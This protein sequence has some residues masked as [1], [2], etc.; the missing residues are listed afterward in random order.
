[1][2]ST[3]LGRGVTA[4]ATAALDDAVAAAVEARVLPRAA[5]QTV[6][7][8][9]ASLSRAVASVDAA[10]AELRLERVLTCRRVTVTPS[11][12]GTAELHALLSADGAA[13]VY[14]AVDA[15]ARAADAADGRGVDQR[16][17]DALVDLVMA[18]TSG[19]PPPA[20]SALVHVTVPAAT[21]LGLGDEPGEL[22]G[23]GPVPASVARRLA[24]GGNWRR[25][26]IDP[27]TGAVRDV[28]RSA[29]TP[30]AALADLIRARDRTCR[31][32]GCRQPCARCGLDHL[33]PWPAGPTTA[34][35]LAS[36]CRHH[37]RLKHQT[38]W[39]VEAAD[40]GLTWTSP[41]G[42]RYATSAPGP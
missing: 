15:V 2:R 7:Q 9:R 18:G 3:F 1:V 19:G 37:H 5:D 32:P 31:F 26:E 28:G 42:H 11:P 14:A 20:V 29:Y 17:A 24:S 4:E 8:L 30:S 35:N 38:R 34:A 40:G 21:V 13:A 23:H 33:V 10:G 41:T 25:V 6:G 22:A 39:R 27:A 16:R 36:L 12:D